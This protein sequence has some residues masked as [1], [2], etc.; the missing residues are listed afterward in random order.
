[1]ILFL[2]TTPADKFAENE[3]TFQAVLN[4]LQVSGTQTAEQQA[5][6]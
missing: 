1:V 6:Q 2:M 5:S 4:S 3:Q